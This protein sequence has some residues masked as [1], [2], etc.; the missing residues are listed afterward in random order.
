MDNIHLRL[1][2]YTRQKIFNAILH[3]YNMYPQQRG[4]QLLHGRLQV[5][6]VRLARK[7]LRAYVCARASG[8]VVACVRALA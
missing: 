1:I 8:S 3:M 6:L 2:P 7:R 5:P 4:L